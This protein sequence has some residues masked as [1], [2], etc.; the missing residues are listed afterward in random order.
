MIDI[1]SGV[2]IVFS[3]LLIYLVFDSYVHPMITIKSEVN[4]KSYLVQDDD[5]KRETADLLA[6]LSEK[7]IRLITYLLETYP[8]NEK[9]RR[10]KRFKP[11]KLREKKPSTSGT[12]FTLGKR[13]IILCLKK[14]NNSELIDENTAFF[15]LLHEVAHVMTVSVG[16]TEQFWENFKFLLANSIDQN[17]Y[18]YDNYEESVKY[19]GI[20]ITSSPL[21]F[22]EVDDYVN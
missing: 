4:S 22:E 3:I 10:L 14:N 18:I 19:C 20:E 2:V 17:L 13:A 6:K 21:N 1:N 9:I 8:D 11:Y 16:H 5:L 12:S 7:S 15:V